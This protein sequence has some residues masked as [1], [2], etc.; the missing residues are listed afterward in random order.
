MLD[1]CTNHLSNAPTLANR[2]ELGKKTRTNAL[3]SKRLS[4]RPTHKA[5]EEPTLDRHR[6]FDHHVLKVRREAIVEQ[7]GQ[8]ADR[9]I[10]PDC[11]NDDE[12]VFNLALQQH[13]AAWILQLIQFPA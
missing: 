11:E 6:V 9:S 3:A 5:I 1:D 13:H 2:E 7:S 4:P 8:P 10:R 12:V